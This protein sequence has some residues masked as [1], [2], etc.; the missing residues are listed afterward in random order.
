MGEILIKEIFLQRK[1]IHTLNPSLYPLSNNLE[2]YVLIV[3]IF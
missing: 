1:H 3:G 2:V